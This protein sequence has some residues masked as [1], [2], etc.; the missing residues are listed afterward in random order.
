MRYI[1]ALMA[2]LG[3]STVGQAADPLALRSF[4]ADRPATI[5]VF[6]SPSCPHC[7]AYHET[8][9][10]IVMDEFVQT[11]QAQVKVVDMPYDAAALRVVMLARCMETEPY[12]SFMTAIYRRQSDWRYDGK[13]MDRIA[14]LAEEVGMTADA[15]KACLATQGISERIM[16]Q[17]DNLA[18]LYR[19]RM[20]PS[21]VVD[22]RGNRPVV[23]T[24]TDADEIR[25]EIN[26]ALGK[27]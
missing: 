22:V 7:A 23:L 14:A 6:T 4:G 13:P 2:L 5:Y 20:M 17:R 15:Q 19:I 9:W 10:P 24:G 3:I 11:G 16:E 21:T 25:K 8:V 12:D 1:V 27:K 26:K 18:D